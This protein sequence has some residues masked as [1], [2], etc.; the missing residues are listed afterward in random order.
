[1][2]D[3]S[4]YVIDSSSLIEL[5]IHSPIDVFPIVWEKLEKLIN[6]GLLIAP[7][8]V[9][10][11]ITMQD[12][13]LSDWVKKQKNFFKDI[14]PEQLKIVSEI[15]QKYPSII[16]IERK[17]DADPFVIA[18]AIEMARDQQKTI[19]AIRKIVVTEE[20]LSLKI[21]IPRICKDFNIECMNVI[22][23]FRNEGIKFN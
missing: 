2:S 7:K 23:M 6:N 21:R 19:I 1:M 16:N 18:L 8:E 3:K 9:L 15:L 20:K 10:K 4:I 11:E 5:N 14:T 22:D 12:D 17:Y 13:K